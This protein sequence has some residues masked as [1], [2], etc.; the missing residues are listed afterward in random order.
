VAA[1]AG[2]KVTARA[3]SPQ[4]RK[5][6]SA[7]AVPHPFFAAQDNFQPQ[8]HLMTSKQRLQQQQQRS[9]QQAR[10]QKRASIRQL[11]SLLRQQVCDS[12]PNVNRCTSCLVF[13]FLVQVFLGM[14]ASS[15]PVRKDVPNVKEDLDS[16]GVRFVYFSAQNMKRSK[17]VA[18][19]IGIPFD[20]NCAISL[21]E[22]EGGTGAHDPHRHISNYADW[23]V[24]G[25]TALFDIVKLFSS[26]L[27]RRTFC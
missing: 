26:S 6:A 5:H 12:R 7:Y 8:A 22:L 21:R 16:A 27:L 18:E 9:N 10:Q 11:W 20:W 24:L 23:D 1:S 17:P 4:L 13:L 19:K 2:E 14:A 15:V 3:G 25:K